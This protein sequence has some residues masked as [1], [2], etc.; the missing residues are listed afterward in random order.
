ML[1]RRD[2]I[3]STA[4]MAFL[5]PMGTAD[6]VPGS[7]MSGPTNHDGIARSAT[8]G[9]ADAEMD[10]QLLRSLGV[11]NYMGGSVGET[12]AAIRGIKDGDPR[13]WPAAFAALGDQTNSV[14][15]SALEKHPV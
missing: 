4:L 9:F 7:T 2:A 8:R 12:L 11:A 6:A 13:T 5:T 14:A 1:T 15:L 3:L 10:F